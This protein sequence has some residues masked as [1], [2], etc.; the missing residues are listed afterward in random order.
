MRS[1]LINF[2]KIGILSYLPVSAP[3]GLAEQMLL[4]SIERKG[5]RAKVY[6][7]SRCQLV[8]DAKEPRVLYEW[9]GLSN[10]DVIIPRVG[11]SRRSLKMDLAVIKQF[12]LMGKTV[13]NKFSSITRAKNKIRTLQL[14]DHAD[15]PVPRTV[16]ITDSESINEAYENEGVDYIEKAVKKV[17]GPPVI[18]KSAT[19][20]TGKGVVIAESIRAAKGTIDLMLGN[21]ENRKIIMV[22]EYLAESKGRDRRLF[23]VDGK[24]VAAMER[25]SAKNDFRSNMARGGG[26][27]AITPTEEEA[28]I[29][30]RAVEAIGLDV[31]G[32]DLIHTNDGP[33]VLEV[34]C[35]PGFKIAEVT[36]V[37]VADCIVDFA[38]KKAKA[39]K[40][41]K[42]IKVRL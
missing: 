17:G 33:A 39:L 27:V 9:K 10:V 24:V 38:I 34:N 23:I 1:N 32:V 35:N 13:V 18:L 7:S 36:G 37:N 22:Q 31:A 3:L 12:E 2:M 30:I 28:D 4:E 11:I 5:H 25:K 19:G 29:A 6:R 26:A 16:M 21:N 14:L 41:N 20:A 40:A 42:K 15:L 8:V